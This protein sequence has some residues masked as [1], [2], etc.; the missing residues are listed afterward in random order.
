MNI[1]GSYGKRHFTAWERLLTEFRIVVGYISLL[2]WPDPGRLSL[3]HHVILSTSPLNPPTTLLSIL[4]L[5]AMTWWTVA[6]RRAYPLITYGL[7]WFILNLL[8]EST[9]VALELVFDHRMYLPSVGFLMSIVAGFH[10]LLAARWKK[11]AA[12]SL[13]LLAWCVVG[14]LF[15]ALSLATFVRNEVWQDFV[16][17]HTDDVQKQPDSPRTHANLSVTLAREGRYDEAIQEARKTL[18]LSQWNYEEYGVAAHTI[19]YS[20]M[21]LQKPGDAL[22]AGEKLLKEWPEYANPYALPTLSMVMGIAKL[23]LGDI[24]GG[25]ISFRH[26]LFLNQRLNRRIYRFEESCIVALEMYFRPLNKDDQRHPLARIPELDD[27]TPRLW[28]AREVLL[29]GDP[30]TALRLYESGL[31]EDPRHEESLKTVQRLME[32]GKLNARQV[33][34]WSFEKKYVYEPFTRFNMAM[35]VAYLVK[36]RHLDLFWEAGEVAIDYALA[37]HPESADAHLLKAWY[38]FEKNKSAEAI[39]EAGRALALDPEYA[40]SWLGLG[41]FLSRTED[42]AGAAQAF[43]KVLEL[44]P[45]YPNR[46]ALMDVISELEGKKAEALQNGHGKGERPQPSSPG[47]K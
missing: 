1:L 15:S 2:L 29:L 46:F 37:L 16:T 25:L 7:L 4:L 44:Y 8:I 30:E 21:A 17:L 47:P 43:R 10:S 39:S 27:H 33:Q 23:Q 3:E 36:E 20:Y 14:L 32:E 42:S 22:E 34:S 40:K 12:K 31:T 18:A 35:A 28:V 41:F 6:K 24:P 38:F 11:F 13:R 5:S 19:L 9:V 45:A 26:A